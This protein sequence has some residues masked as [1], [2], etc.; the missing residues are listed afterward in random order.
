[1]PSETARETATSIQDLVDRLGINRASLYSTFGDKKALFDQAS[2]VIAAP[3]QRACRLFSGS[4][5]RS[6][7]A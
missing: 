5:P 2:P 3:K 6:A 4:K 7:R 1:M